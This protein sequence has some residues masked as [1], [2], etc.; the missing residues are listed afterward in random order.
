MGSEETWLLSFIYPTLSLFLGSLS[1]PKGFVLAKEEEN[2]VKT[3]ELT[4][5]IISRTIHLVFPFGFQ[6]KHF[7][8]GNLVYCVNSMSCV[9]IL[10]L[11]SLLK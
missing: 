11:A 6:G 4:K 10:M 7:V 3:C 2:I 8:H 1:F 9:T 5:R